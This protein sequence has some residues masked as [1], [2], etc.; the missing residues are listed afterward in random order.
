MPHLN[1]ND[2]TGATGPKKYGVGIR[3][4]AIRLII[5][6][7]A[8]AFFCINRYK[9]LWDKLTKLLMGDNYIVILNSF[10]HNCEPF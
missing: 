1:P 6:A 2:I 3:G 4:V 5:S 8:H 7:R 10:C 9:T